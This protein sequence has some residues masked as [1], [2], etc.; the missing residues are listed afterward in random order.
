MEAKRNG[1]IYHYMYRAR[2]L[3]VLATG[4]PSFTVTCGAATLTF[5]NNQQYDI[6]L[7]DIKIIRVPNTGGT[8]SRV[9]SPPRSLTGAGATLLLTDGTVLVHSEQGNLSDSYTLTPD[10]Y[11]SYVTGTWAQTDSIPASFGYAPLYFASAVLPDGRVIIE[12]GEYNLN[13]TNLVDT[14]LGAIYDPSHYRQQVESGSITTHL[15]EYR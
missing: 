8:W 15:V 11:G 13:N 12:G 6:G 5:T 9:T 2:S 7:D 4:K 14:N 10:I 3:G 1:I